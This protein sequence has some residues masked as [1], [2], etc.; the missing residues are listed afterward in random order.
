MKPGVIE[1]FFGPAWPMA[2]RLTWAPFAR[3]HG[4]D[5][6]LYAPKADPHLRKKWRDEWPESYRTELASMASHFRQ[7][8]V[9]FG[10]GFSPFGLGEKLSNEDRAEISRKIGWLSAAGVEILGIFF[11][12]MKATPGLARMQIEVIGL[13]RRS[14]KGRLI[15]CPTYYSD[16]PI[17]DRVFGARDPAYVG[18][19]GEGLPADVEVAWT[20]PKV[21]SDE[22]PAEH[23]RAVT[24]TLRRKPFLWDN[25]FANDGPKNCLFLKL[26][27][28]KGRVLESARESSAW[29]F[30]P[31]N[32]CHLSKVVVLASL[33]S[34]N[35]KG[36]PAEA[37][38]AAL[39]ALCSPGLARFVREHRT[40]FLTSGLTSFD[41]EEK[42]SLANEARSFGE[43]IGDEIARW[44]DGEYVVGSE[45]LT[46]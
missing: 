2:D 18:D 40:R 36:S 31:M 16:D 17:L 44:L 30:N 26:K 27:E 9:H 4:L 35:G 28:P 37:F 41:S 23:L 34:L 21:I 33:F 14:W 5:F 7:Q 46:D 11:D 12:D 22:I 32:Q 38:E 39:D 42:R 1:G 15:F 6:F 10:V 24:A 43:P 3:E 29:A 13:I 19:I 45:C 20:G 8:G 25:I